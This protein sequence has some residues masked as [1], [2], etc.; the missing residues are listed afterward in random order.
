[1]LTGRRQLA[2]TSVKPGKTQTINHFL[3]NNSWYLVDLPGYGYARLSKDML[4]GLGKIIGN[5]VTKSENLC[6]LFVL[7]DIRHEPQAN[8]LRFIQWAGGLH[9]PLAIVFTKSD[10]LDL[11]KGLASRKRYEATLLKTWT[12]L[13]PLFV[14]SAETKK[15]RDELLSFIDQALTREKQN[16]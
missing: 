12:E 8:D 16:H 9:I 2:K 3:I 4:Q 1:M 11:S 10:K 7:V 15:G 5:Y 13:P 14:T 6:C